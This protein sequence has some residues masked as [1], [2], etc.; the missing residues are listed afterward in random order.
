M[1][2]HFGLDLLSAEWPRAVVCIGTFDG[3]HLGHRAV[4]AEAVRRASSEGLPCLLVTF[5]RHPAAVLDPDR[6]PPA[7]AGLG[8][9][10]AEFERA[11]VEIAVVLR[12]DQALADTTAETFF[13][14][15]LLGSLHASCL[16][17]GHDFAFGWARRG[18]PGWLAERIETHVVPPFELDGERVSSSRVREAIASGEFERVSR[19]LG[20]PWEM[21]GIVVSGERLGR[22]FGYP[23]ANLARSIRQATPKDGVYAGTAITP[24]GEFRAA[25]SLGD[26]PTLEG[27]EHAVEAYLLDYPGE[28]LYGKN[29]T[30]RFHRLLREQRRFDSVEDL[31]AQIAEDV[32][33]VAAG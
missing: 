17:V 6:C 21:S 1:Q 23:T 30:L 32:R 26:R 31:R 33:H 15:T 25:I 4:I 16:V 22:T 7:I 18:T 5:D 24:F 9:N 3:V 12:F 19:W 14:E 2:V 27:K 13:E 28:S 20:R 8:A 29:V 10:L 11:G